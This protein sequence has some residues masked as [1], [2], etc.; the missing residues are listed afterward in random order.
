MNLESPLAMLVDRCQTVC[1]SECCGIDAYDFNPIHIASYLI[2]TRG[3]PDPAEVAELQAQ[4]STLRLNYGSSGVT[5][6]GATFDDL[7]QVF[8]GEEIDSLVQ[9]ILT[10]IDRALAMIAQVRS[11][12]T[13]R[14]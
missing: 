1:V 11:E 2:L 12:G 5:A 10:N 14:V 7:N 3:S 9:L 8:S 4:L 6:R 13:N